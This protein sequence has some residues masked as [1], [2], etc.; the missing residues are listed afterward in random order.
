[1]ADL[2]NLSVEELRSMLSSIESSSAPT[3]APTASTSGLNWRGAA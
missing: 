3:V 2:E 1:M